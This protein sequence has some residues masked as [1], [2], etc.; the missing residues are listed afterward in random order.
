[1]VTAA[2][3]KK[4]R[5]AQSQPQNFALRVEL[6]DT[7]PLI[8]RR[9]HVDGRTRL[10]ALHHILQAVM[11]WADAHLHS[12]DIGDKHYGVPDPEMADLDWEVLDEG[13][14]RLN[15]LLSQGE[16]FEYMYDFGDSWMHRITVEAITPIES[17]DSDGGFA[18][19]EAGE[20]A[21]PPEDAGGVGGYQASLEELQAKPKGQEAKSFLRWAGVGFDPARFDRHA[22]NAAISRMLSNGWIR[23]RS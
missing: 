20:R 10:A 16:S 23:I 13:K 5:S 1:V 2:K 9:V 7:E 17:D 19:I 14:Y 6:L 18:W 12:F 11:G 8:W 15:Q 21:C 4:H 22:A 3:P